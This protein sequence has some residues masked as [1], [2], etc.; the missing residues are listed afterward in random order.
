MH[1]EYNEY[2]FGRPVMEINNLD[3][4]LAV[5]LAFLNIEN[6]SFQNGIKMMG[7]T[8]ILTKIVALYKSKKDEFEMAEEDNDAS[9]VVS[10]ALNQA[11]EEYEGDGKDYYLGINSIKHDSE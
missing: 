10:N 3:N 2:S 6:T 8:F 1:E 7:E 4:I 11:L 5:K 9:D